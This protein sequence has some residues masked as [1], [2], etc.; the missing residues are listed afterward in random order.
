VV[1]V[2]LKVVYKR[3]ESFHNEMRLFILNPV[4]GNML[5][6]LENVLA[7]MVEDAL[8]LLQSDWGNDCKGLAQR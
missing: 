2:D 1:L 8:K 7:V 5:A 3:K 6:R 4:K